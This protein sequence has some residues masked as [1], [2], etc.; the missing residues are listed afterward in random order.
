MDTRGYRFGIGAALAALVIVCVGLGLYIGAIASPPKVGGTNQRAHA[1]QR[2]ISAPNA[3]LPQAPRGEDANSHCKQGEDNRHSDLCA[4]WKAADAASDSAVWTR[5]AGYAAYAGV[6]IAFFTLLAAV[7]AALFARLA[8]RHTETGAKAAQA[9]VHE[10]KRIGEA[11]VRSYLSILKAEIKF[12]VKGQVD[13]RLT[14]KNSGQSPAERF[15]LS[16]WV[17]IQPLKGAVPDQN[18]HAVT[19]DLSASISAGN[20]V[21]FPA[22]TP[23]TPVREDIIDALLDDIPVAVVVMLMVEWRD[24]F[25]ARRSLSEGFSGVSSEWPFED[26]GE[27]PHADHLIAAFRRVEIQRGKRERSED[28]G[29]HPPPPRRKDD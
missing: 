11:Q 14:I 2:V 20:S 16:C 24:V 12:N 19:K 7:A 8:A 4:Q 15:K 23:A 18:L 25:G 10:T 21:T 22:Q 26:F 29:D 28:E 13:V 6:L 3:A 9:A 5:R 17:T 27:M 1:Q